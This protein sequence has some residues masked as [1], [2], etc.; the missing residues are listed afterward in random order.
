MSAIQVHFYTGVSDPGD[1][2]LR[3]LARARTQQ[4]RAWVMGPA[5]TLRA[6]S[7]RL[8]AQ[9]GFW[10]HAAPGEALQSR[11]SPVVLSE[12]PPQPGD[13]AVA[14]HLGLEQAVWP[15]DV[16]YVFE[17]VATEEPDVSAGRRR[18]QAYKAAGLNPRHHA[19]CEYE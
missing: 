10:A 6:L 1:R 13:A 3:L 15:P 16:Q 4:L 8:W 9:S 5:P 2:V 17:V 12:A 11:L 18:F 14:I 7:E 19:A